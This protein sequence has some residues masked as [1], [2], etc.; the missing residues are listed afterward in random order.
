MLND[1]ANE[2]VSIHAA[3]ELYGVKINAERLTV[4]DEGTAALR[5][6][7]RADRGAGWT[8]PLAHPWEW[9]LDE[10]EFER[11]RHAGVVGSNQQV[12]TEV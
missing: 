12:H 11:L 10:S 7:M 4:D 3:A 9:P 6:H 8:T 2:L 1:V 5:E